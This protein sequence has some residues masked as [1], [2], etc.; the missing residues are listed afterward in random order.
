MKFSGLLKA[1]LQR[2]Q[3]RNP[4]YSLRAFARDLGTD[5][6]TLSQFLRGRRAASV[7]RI[8]LIGGR[9][10]LHTDAIERCCEERRD[11]AVLEAIRRRPAQVG[12]RVLAR[13]I[14]SRVDDI[15]IV[16]HRLLSSGRLRMPATNRWI[17]EEKTDA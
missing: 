14:G 1:E 11:A 15:N 7:R 9:I 8:R 2:R 13:R 17:I 5:H 12:S 6:A 4:R 16:L 3:T 10:G